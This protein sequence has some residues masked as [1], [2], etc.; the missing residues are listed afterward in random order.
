MAREHEYLSNFD[1]RYRE[2]NRLGT[3]NGC[4]FEVMNK[5]PSAIFTIFLLAFGAFLIGA[6]SCFWFVALLEAHTR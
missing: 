5:P 4:A 3:R 1:V 2:A 6:V